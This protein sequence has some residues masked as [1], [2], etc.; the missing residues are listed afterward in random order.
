MPSDRH[1]DLYREV[2]RKPPRH[3]GQ[4][5]FPIPHL[6]GQG[7]VA[8]GQIAEIVPLPQRVIGVLHR[9]FSPA[10][11]AT[12]ASAHVGHP[13]V[14]GQ[15]TDRPAVPGM[16]CTVITSTCSRSVTMKSLAR[17]GIS[18]VSSSGES[19]MASPSREAGHSAASM[20]CQPK[21]AFRRTGLAA[22]V[23]RRPPKT[24][25]A[26]FRGGP[27]HRPPPHSARRYQAARAAAMRPPCCRPVRAPATGG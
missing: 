6:R 27:P 13:H 22:G 19:A 20:T 8:I 4:G 26:G 16:W 7:T 25:C 14:R 18:L 11:G 10:R 17:E 3:P 2:R 15:H 21:S 24:P 1:A 5:I 23:S 9:Q 12:G